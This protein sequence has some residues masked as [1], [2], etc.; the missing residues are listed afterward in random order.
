VLERR[1][2]RKRGV[3]AIHRVFPGKA[4]PRQLKIFLRLVFKKWY[5]VMSY[6]S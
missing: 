3:L 6:F 2:G 4:F 1:E 5:N